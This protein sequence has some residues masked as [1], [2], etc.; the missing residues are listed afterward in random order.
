MLDWKKKFGLGVHARS[1]HFVMPTFALDLEPGFVAG[2]RLD[3]HSRQVQRMG[4]RHLEEGALEP[5]PNKTNLNDGKAVRETVGEVAA[6]I[7]NIGGRI[8]LLLPDVAVRVAVLQFEGLPDNHREAESLIHWKMR[9][10]LP[11]SPDEAR[12]SHQ[13]MV[14]E[15]GRVEILGLA[16]RESVLAEYEAAMD[17]INGG[18]ALVLPS[19]VALLPLLP[20]DSPAQLLLHFSPGA[21]TAVVLSLGRVRYWRTRPLEAAAGAASQDEVAR[22]AAR[23]MATCQDHLNLQVQDVWFCARPSAPP[24]IQDT[25]AKTLGQELRPLSDLRAPATKLPA[26]EQAAFEEFGMPFAG[27]VANQGERR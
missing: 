18:P 9:E 3:P 17:V 5:S 19:S 23:V 15:P 10:Y 26:G 22:E 25:L 24:E 14:K 6:L 27:L 2:A 4:V 12:V 11:F 13:V 1:A 8:G 21:L 16:V 7:G 20:D